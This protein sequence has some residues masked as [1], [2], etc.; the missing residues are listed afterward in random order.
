M[1]WA[2][3]ASSSRNDR[4][5]ATAPEGQ[6]VCS[7]GLTPGPLPCP[8][9]SSP[10]I[11]LAFCHLGNT[12]MHSLRTCMEPRTVVI[13][14]DSL[15]WGGRSAWALVLPTAWYVQEKVKFTSCGGVGYRSIYSQPACISGGVFK[16]IMAVAASMSGSGKINQ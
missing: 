7:L 8:R 5:P 2:P 16:S 10:E 11:I 6:R 9:V 1:N 4:L 15:S 14:S 3:A 12:P 13:Q